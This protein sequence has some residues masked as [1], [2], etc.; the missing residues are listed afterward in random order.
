[1]ESLQGQFLIA[2]NQM[3]DPRFAE[4][5]IYI[6][7]HDLD[8]VMGLVI[9]QPSNHSLKEVFRSANIVYGDIP[10]PPIYIGGP[11]DTESA[12]FLYSSGY[13]NKNSFHVSDK[14]CMSRDPQ[15]LSD[16]GTGNG[17]NDYLFILGYAGWGPGQLETELT[18]NG[19]LA[20]PSS[21]EILFHISNELKWKK[22]AADNGI[23]ISLYT[24]EI[25]L[26]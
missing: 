4:Q 1:M 3:P 6:C 17:P 15:I 22:A 21:Y 20:L 26:A 12:F 24:D 25:G 14:V 2:T 11:V 19:W 18:L 16:I 7:S 8:G 9:N 5:V 23:D 10:L 13:E